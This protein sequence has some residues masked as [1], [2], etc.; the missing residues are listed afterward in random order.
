MAAPKGNQYA[1]N[2]R[3]LS[4]HLRQRL[5]ERQQGIRLMD[6][7]IDKALE[8]DMPAIKEIFDRVDGKAQQDVNIGGQE[9]NPLRGEWT[10]LP[11]ATNA[12]NPDR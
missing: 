1:K 8:G 10:V 4:K 9:D 6:I 3:L 11:V 5:E 2:A 12:T 7:L